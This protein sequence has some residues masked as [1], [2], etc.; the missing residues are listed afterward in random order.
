MTHQPHTPLVAGLLLA[1][2]TA[3]CGPAATTAPSAAPSLRPTP[4]P[5]AAV[6]ATPADAAALVIATNP[7]FA[8]AI[9]LTPDV[10][11]ASKWWEATPLAGGGY[12]V[13]LTVGWGDCPSG[14]ISRHVWTFEVK[15][16]GGVRLVSETGEPV[17]S[18]LPA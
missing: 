12:T 5:I 14:C 10:I 7:L 9:P 13:V 4:T 18:V 2:V 8:G 11:G 17:P 16:D 6:V 3:A 1:V 15:A